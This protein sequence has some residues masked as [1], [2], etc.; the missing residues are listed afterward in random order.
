MYDSSKWP[1]D[2][3]KQLLLQKI[4]WEINIYPSNGV[5]TAQKGWKQ[6]DRLHQVQGIL[7]CFIDTY[8]YLSEYK[9][10]KEVL[11]NAYKC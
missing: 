8:N 5:K 2:K 10:I 4:F 11:F 1:S 7:R 6:L 9:N 3:N